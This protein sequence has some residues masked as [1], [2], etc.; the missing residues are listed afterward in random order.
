MNKKATLGI[1][2]ITSIFLLIV[3]LTITNFL[4][5]EVTNFRVDMNCSSAAD[6]TD[7]QKLICL[8]GDL[9]VPYWIYIVFALVIGGIIAKFTL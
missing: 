5:P 9:V 6:I 2:I 8:V 4:F 3:G 7:G 1:T